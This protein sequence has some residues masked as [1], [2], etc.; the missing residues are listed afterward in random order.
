MGW[1]FY[2]P[3]FI[4]KYKAQYRGQILDFNVKESEMSFAV[5]LPSIKIKL[6][7]TTYKW[8]LQVNSH[9]LFVKVC[10]ASLIWMISPLFSMAKNKGCVRKKIA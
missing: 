1:L 6:S 4:G 8:P 3:F 5:I 2:D 10:W 9:S 7:L